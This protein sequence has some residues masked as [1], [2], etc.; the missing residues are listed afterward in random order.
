MLRCN[1]RA[2]AASSASAASFATASLHELGSSMS[3]GCAKAAVAAG[4][5]EAGSEDD[6][7]AGEDDARHASKRPEPSPAHTPPQPSPMGDQFSCYRLTRQ[8][9]TSPGSW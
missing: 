9:P 2:T 5:V 4:L 1:S 8:P 7:T 3:G 6:G